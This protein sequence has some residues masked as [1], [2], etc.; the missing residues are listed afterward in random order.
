MSRADPRCDSLQN[1]RS[2]AKRF[3][4][5]L[6]EGWIERPKPSAFPPTLK[7]GLD[8][9]RAFPSGGQIEIRFGGAVEDAAGIRARLGHELATPHPV[10]KVMKAKQLELCTL[11][12]LHLKFNIAVLD[13]RITQ[14]TLCTGGTPTG[15]RARPDEGRQLS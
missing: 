12:P 8:N 6:F 3:G 14:G 15:P 2:L 7:G 5:E 1:L 11:L 13:P 4:A 9:L 10:T